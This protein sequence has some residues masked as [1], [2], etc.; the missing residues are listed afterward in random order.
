MLQLAKIERDP[1]AARARLAATIS[2]G[3]ALEVLRQMIAAQGGDPAIVDDPRLLA[4]APVQRDVLAER[5]GVVT[6]VEPRALGRV[7]IE[8]GGGRRAVTDAVL[9]DVGLEVFAK[10]GAAVR[11]GDRLAVVH[12]RSQAAADAV[13][14]AVLAAVTIGDVAIPALPL[15]AWRVSVTGEQPYGAT[16]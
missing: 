11:R 2:S 5:D 15:I 7:I 14:P 3:A 6:Q 10:P 1:A 12:A 16:L 9:P 4:R 13:A 8:L